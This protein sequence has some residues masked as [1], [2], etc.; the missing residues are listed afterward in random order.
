[1]KD[2]L[3]YL[4]K[5]VIGTI[6]TIGMLIVLFDVNGPFFHCFDIFGT[7]QNLIR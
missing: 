6:L 5:F 1:M 3:S 2:Y 4:F 7:I